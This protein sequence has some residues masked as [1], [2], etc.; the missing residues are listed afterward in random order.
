MSEATITPA[1][2]TLSADEA[3][4]R[5]ELLA[6]LAGRRFFLRYTVD[7][8]DDT[9]ATSRSTV[10]A[11]N[12]AGLI[13]HVALTEQ[14][15]LRFVLEGPTAFDDNPIAHEDAF[16]LL[17]GETLAGVLD[18]YARIAQRTEQIITNEI[19][20]LD[21]AHPLPPRPWFQPGTQWSAR[22][23]LLHL[24]GETAQHSGHADI[25]REAIDGH[26]TMG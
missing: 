18:L 8:L 24:I 4:A 12:L 14:E 15:W 11:L 7:G 1:H 5:A 3:D 19:A 10:S 9:Q 2:P 20:S 17:P 25:L 23:V 13:K 22:T 21:Q 6:Q 16:R 26:R